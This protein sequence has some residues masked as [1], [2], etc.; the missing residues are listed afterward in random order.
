VPDLN[1]L[2]PECPAD[3]KLMVERAMAKDSAQRYQSAAEMSADLGQSLSAMQAPSRA[4]AAVGPAAIAVADPHRTGQAAVSDAASPQQT[5]TP[6]ASVSAAP[7]RSDH[8]RVKRSLKWFPP[9][10]PGSGGRSSPAC[11]WSER[12]S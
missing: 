2:R 9:V 11:S 5:G 7:R 10:N 8:P 1:Q 4:P 6:A 3:L 12:W